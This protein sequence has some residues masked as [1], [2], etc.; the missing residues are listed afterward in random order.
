MKTKLISSLCAGLLLSSLLSTNVLANTPQTFKSLGPTLQ[1]EHTLETNSK[2]T[3][4]LTL[5]SK[6]DKSGGILNSKKV[7]ATSDS[8]LK[9]KGNLYA[10]DYIYAKARW[11]TSSGALG[12]QSSDSAYNSS[13]AGIQV[14]TGKTNT[15]GTG[16]GNHTY[17]DAGMNTTDH[18]TRI[19]L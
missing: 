10:I 7:I 16:Y 18:E 1:T 9:S 13:H 15:T 8:K 6:V 5:N 4:T 3:V 17:R 12:G 14:D 11:Y 2:A 19:Q